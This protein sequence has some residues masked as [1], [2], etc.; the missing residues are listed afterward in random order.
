VVHMVRNSLSYVP[1][2]DKKLVATDLKTIYS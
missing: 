2:K 1:Y